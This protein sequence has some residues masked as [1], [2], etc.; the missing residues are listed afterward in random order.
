MTTP[1]PDTG[2]RQPASITVM[3]YNIRLDVSRDGGN[4]WAYR[5]DDVNAV[6]GNADP[7]VFCVQEAL[8]HQ[9][10][11]LQRLNGYDCV[12]FGRDDGAGAGEHAG[13]FFR[14][15]RFNLGER[16]RFWL[17][18]TPDL[19]SAGWGAHYRRMATWVNLGDRQTGKPLTLLCTHLDHKSEEARVNGAAVL[20]ERLGRIAG[21]RPV[22]L[23]GDFNETPERPAIQLLLRHL[24]DCRA[25][26]QSPAVGPDGTFNDFT[27]QNIV[28]PVRIDYIFITPD[29]TVLRQSHIV[30]ITPDGRLPSDHFPVLA[31]V[32]IRPRK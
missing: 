17:S 11:D 25:V 3:T 6:I 21:G 16:G 2:E 8:P 26:S 23:A 29:V 27:F 1:Q 18:P 31:Q 19:P 4:S 32:Q 15:G 22:I 30:T 10:Q 28:P 20:I 24:Q 7:D 9:L 14:A 13:I 5:R 12:A